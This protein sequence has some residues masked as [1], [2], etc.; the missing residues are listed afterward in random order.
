MKKD[1]L[2]L[3]IRKLSQ[4]INVLEG[5][6]EAI[7]ILKHER[8]HYIFMYKEEYEVCYFEQEL[9]KKQKDLKWTA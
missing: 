5:N 3:K 2:E 4:A 7:E 6:D 9:N 8:G 1:N